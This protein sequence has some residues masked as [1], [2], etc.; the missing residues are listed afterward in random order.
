MYAAEIW[1]LTILFGFMREELEK[2]ARLAS[3]NDFPDN[4]LVHLQQLL[5]SEKMAISK[6]VTLAHLC[7]CK[8]PNG[9]QLQKPMSM[10]EREKLL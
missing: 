8:T 4:T 1:R 6:L 5:S 3:V 9:M 7:R 10:K 2:A